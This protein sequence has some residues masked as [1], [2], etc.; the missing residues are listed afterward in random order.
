M[1]SD[2]FP[3]VFGKYKSDITILMLCTYL[4]LVCIV[5]QHNLDRSDIGL[6]ATLWSFFKLV[7]EIRFYIFW[8]LITIPNSVYKIISVF[9][10]GKG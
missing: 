7:F 6:D 1:V 9:L 4:V 3:E 2:R 5:F 10:N 8:F